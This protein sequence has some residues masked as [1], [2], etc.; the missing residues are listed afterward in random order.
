VNMKV[1]TID[2]YLS[3]LEADKR[4]A[5]ERL[6]KIVKSAAPKSEECISYRLPAF[7]LDGRMLIWFGAGANHCAL[8][9][10]GTVGRF[11]K[12]LTGFSI[13]KGTIRFQPDHPLPASLVKKIVKARIAER[14]SYRS[15]RNTRSSIG[16]TL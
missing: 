8:Y 16:T 14:D 12:Q 6:R 11:R 5:L 1:K 10:G 9:P 13:S 2:G 4:A 3:L 7:R 15:K